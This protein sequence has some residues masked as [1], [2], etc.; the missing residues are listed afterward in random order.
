[1]QNRKV[2][3]FQLECVN[4]DVFEI[5]ETKLKMLKWHYFSLVASIYLF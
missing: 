3:I 1:M 4:K 5:D 2:K